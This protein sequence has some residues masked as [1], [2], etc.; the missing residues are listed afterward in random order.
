V[1]NT[2]TTTHSMKN[3][4]PPLLSLFSISIEHYNSRRLNTL[5]QKHHELAKLS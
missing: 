1:V 3:K 5:P 4:F 2:H